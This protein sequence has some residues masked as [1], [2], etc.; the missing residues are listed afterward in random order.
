MYRESLPKSCPPED[1]EEIVASRAVYRFVRTNPPR[2]EDFHSQRAAKPTT[3]FGV[4]ECR[5]RGLSVFSDLD[6]CLK[7]KKL[8]NFKNRMV[9]CVRLD[10]GAGRIQRWGSEPAHHTWWPLAAYNILASCSIEEL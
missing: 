2:E 4:D 7:Y 1:S 3:S 9:C 6:T 5:A 10:E 8:P